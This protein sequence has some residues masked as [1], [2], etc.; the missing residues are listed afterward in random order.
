MLYEKFELIYVKSSGHCK[1]LMAHD[2][3]ELGKVETALAI[4]S[5]AVGGE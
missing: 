1:A 4:I 3:C 2:L 5:R